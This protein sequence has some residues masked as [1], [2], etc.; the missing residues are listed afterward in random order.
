VLLIA[1]SLA[2]LAERTVA[3]GPA[4]PIGTGPV[5]LLDA[6]HHNIVGRDA[7]GREGRAGLIRFLEADGYRVRQLTTE[8]TERVL[9]GGH[10]VI[11]E[12]PLSKQNALPDNPTQEEVENAWRLPTPSAFTEAEITA[13]A[14]WVRAGGSVLIVFDHMP[15]AGA[16][17]SLAAA[18]DVEVSNG[19]AVDSVKLHEPTPASV[20]QA[21]PVVFRRTD[22]TLA[23]HPI[24]DG[25]SPEER[26]DS[27]ATWV[28]SAF[29]P[30]PTATSLLPLGPSFIS[31]LPNVAWVFSDSTPRESV[32]GWSQGAVF[33]LDRGRV[34]VFSEHAVLVTPEMRAASDKSDDPQVQNPQLLLNVIHWL[35]RVL[36]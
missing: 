28:G 1:A 14:D 17:Q 32:G 34:A 26:V 2:V 36:D 3:Q 23:E 19:Y 30:P 22:G 15:L 27:V 33:E 8:F 18:F 9:S 25:R 13:L 4:Y 35:S 20:A 7:L 6:A 10:V 31:L 16:I 11:I 21:A 12:L 5:I 29:H 24:T